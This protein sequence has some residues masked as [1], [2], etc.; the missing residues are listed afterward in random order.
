ML[1]RLTKLRERWVASDRSNKNSLLEK[2]NDLE[3]D[4]RNKIELNFSDSPLSP[5]RDMQD[6]INESNNPTHSTDY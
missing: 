4:I 6:R 1:G 3:T 2:M 5:S